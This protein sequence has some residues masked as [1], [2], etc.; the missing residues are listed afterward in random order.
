MP[1]RVCRYFSKYEIF[2]VLRGLHTYT[3]IIGHY[4]PSVSIIDLASHTTYVVCVSFIHKWWDL[5]FK[6]DSKR[7]IF[8]KLFMAIL[9][10][11]RVFARNPLRGC[12][13]EPYA[14][15]VA[16]ARSTSKQMIACFSEKLGM[17]LSYH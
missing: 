12:Q 11:L 15:K 5:Q 9:F 13:N 8:K 3:Y 7:Q 16:R 6:V 1:G 10:T 17:S 2:S 4:N 14:T